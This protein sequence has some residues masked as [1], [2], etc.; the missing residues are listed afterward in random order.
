MVT[1]YQVKAVP[2]PERVELIQYPVSLFDRE[3]DRHGNEWTQENGGYLRFAQLKLL[4]STGVPQRITDARTGE[5]F[6]GS[7]ERVEFIATAPPDR[8]AGNFGG[9]GL[10]TVRRL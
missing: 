2:A 3:V 1:G 7:I 4:E 10:V 8:N 9:V 6:V 5:T